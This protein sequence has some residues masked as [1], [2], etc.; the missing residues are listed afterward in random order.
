MTTPDDNVDPDIYALSIIIDDP[1]V[2]KE[3]V[4]HYHERTTKHINTVGENIEKLYEKNPDLEGLLERAE[5]HDQSKWGENELIPYIVLTWSYK[6]KDD[7]VEY[8]IPDDVQEEIDQAIEH[9]LT[10]NKHHPEYWDNDREVCDA[11][12]MDIIS[13]AEMVCDWHAMSIE[14]GGSTKEWADKTVNK[15]WEF[16]DGQVNDIYKFI[17]DLEGSD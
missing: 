13:L 17:E 4:K 3:M 14:R 9:H 1:R 7:G 15:R 6:C 10:T 5:K 12:K 16:T 2:T 11:S 8:D